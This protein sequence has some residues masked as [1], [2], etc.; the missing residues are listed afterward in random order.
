LVLLQVSVQDV[1][2]RCALDLCKEGSD[3]H[4]LLLQE[5][6][7]LEERAT[8]MAAELLE[9]EDAAL[10]HEERQKASKESRKKK[11]AACKKPPATQARL[12]IRFILATCYS[13]KL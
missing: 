8:R 3:A 13:I 4:L 11:G 7:E 2:G 5:Y 10:V 1:K 6:K 9:E 12:F